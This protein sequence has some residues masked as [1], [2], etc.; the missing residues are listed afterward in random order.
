MLAYLFGFGLHEVLVIVI[1]TAVVV[2]LVT[3]Q[4]KH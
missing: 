4:R 1:V 2:Y 3:R